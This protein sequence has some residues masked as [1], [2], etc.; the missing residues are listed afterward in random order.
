MK[1]IFTYH[2]AWLILATVIAFGYAFFLYRKD[3]LLADVKKN[4]RLTMAFLR[5][6][7]VWLICM[8][9]IG[10]IVENFVDRKEKPLV[11]IAQDNTESILLNNDSAYYKGEYLDQ[12]KQFSAD[13]GEEFEVVEYNFSDVLNEGLNADYSGKLTDLSL[14]FNQIFDQYTN[15][16]IGAIVLASDGIY[17]SG[18]NPIYAIARKSFIPVFTVGLGDTNQVKDLK[19]ESVKH[20]DI[21]FLGNQFPVQVNIAHTKCKDETVKVGIYQSDKLISEKTVKLSKD[22]EQISLDYILSAG[23]IGYQKYTVKTT[24][25]D[26]EFSE[27]NNISNFYVEVIDGRQQ[28]LV[29]HNGP[30]P[31]ISALRYVIEN[32]KNYEVNVLPIDE[33]KETSKYDLIILHNYQ[34]TN[35]N[36]NDVINSGSVPCLFIVGNN[37]NIRALETAKIGFSGNKT[38][39]EE[40]GFT[41]NSNFKDILLSP[42]TV[43]MLNSAPPLQVPF[44]NFNFSG[45]SNVLAY[46][47]IGNII[48]DKPLI[49]FTQ[50]NNSRIGVIM[51]EGIWRWRLHDQSRNGSTTNFEDFIGKIIT[52]L[53]V[54]ENKDPFKVHLKNEYSESENVV[55]KAE[56]YNKSFDLINEPEVKFEY[57]NEAGKTFEPYFVRVGKHYQLDLGKLPQGIYE[58][59]ASTSFQGANYEKKG[60]FLVREVKIESLNNQ[61]DHRLLMNLAENSGGAFYIPSQLD[62]L[63]S[64]IQNRDE[65]VTVVYQERS[66]D[67]LI[68]YKWLLLLIVALLS[69][70]WFLR[71][72]NGAY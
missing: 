30:H 45:G 68:D 6:A 17:N 16:N 20:N 4:I 62:E 49:Y 66:F 67:D 31:D 58:W 71:K 46:Q 69:A 72:Y 19:I 32:N 70:E 54:K 25:L 34:P 3:E 65:L 1:L 44:G 60:T 35:Q 47:K 56:L 5:F 43:R 48:L 11:F 18:A 23:K 22:E 63:S 57:T 61:A 7:S 27:L 33:V 9:L 8:L 13:L 37:S 52:Y 36:I 53:A 39:V 14:V 64:D 42:E 2:P 50:K 51:G 26:R 59:K 21:A 40:V 55:V 15:R 10:I 29:A 24:V 38:D 41:L 12:L 28:L